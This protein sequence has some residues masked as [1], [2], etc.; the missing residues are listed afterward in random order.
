M[1]KFENMDII[2]TLESVMQ[3]NTRHYQSD[4]EYDKISFH[5][6]AESEN[7]EEKVLL[8]M[9]RDAGTWCFQEREIL[10][11]D[12]EAF[13]TWNYYSDSSEN[14]VAFQVEV[15]KVQDGKVIGNLY[16][17]DYHGHLEQLKHASVPASTVLLTFGD[18]SQH[19]FDYEYY[20]ERS[21]RISQKYGEI[22]DFRL[23]PENPD[24][25]KQLIAQNQKARQHLKPSIQCQLK[26]YVLPVL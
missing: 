2:T 22:T 21:G 23:D 17:I 26:L 6:A 7:S 12:S 10:I 13:S 20:K 24:I 3:Q 25:I 4:F 15:R 9:S 8:W 18:G 14:I 11:K 16:E 5:K 1:R 19:R